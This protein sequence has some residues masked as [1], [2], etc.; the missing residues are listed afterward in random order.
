MSTQEYKLTYLLYCDQS[1]EI[2]FKT[3]RKVSTCIYEYHFLTK[4]ACYSNFTTSSAFSSKVILFYLTII[5]SV[6]CLGF[7]V[8]NYRNNPDDGL[9]KSLPHRNFW[10]EF[11]E[12]VKVGASLTLVKFKYFSE[13][14]ITKLKEKYDY[15]KGNNNTGY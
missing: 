3:I 10:I 2:R 1:E 11:I 5:F 4:R 12:N 13:I 14:I 9:I 6:Y 8:M 7:S 15:Y